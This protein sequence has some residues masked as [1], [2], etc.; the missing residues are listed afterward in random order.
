MTTIGVQVSATTFIVEPKGYLPI[1]NIGYAGFTGGV[2][3]MKAAKI[4][5]GEMG[6]TGEG[7]WDGV[8]M[9]TLMRRAM[10]EC[11]SWE[12]VQAWLSKSPRTCEY[13]EVVE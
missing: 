13:Y 3:G 6:G 8:P 7:Q 12:E 1:A 10:E 11:D 9:S 5:L 4:S 2:S